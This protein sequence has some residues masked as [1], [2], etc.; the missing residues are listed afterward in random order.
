MCESLGLED[1]L[2]FLLHSHA[3]RGLWKPVWLCDVALLMEAAPTISD[4]HAASAE[5]NS[6]SHWVLC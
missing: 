2:R 1:H 6:Q 5:T 4:G 3:R